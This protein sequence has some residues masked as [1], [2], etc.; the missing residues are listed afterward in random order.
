MV[1]GGCVALISPTA[2]TWLLL[3]SDTSIVLQHL[4]QKYI[5]A[6]CLLVITSSLLA[7]DE[8]FLYLNTKSLFRANK[9]WYVIT[10]TDRHSALMKSHLFLVF[11]SELQRLSIEVM[12]Q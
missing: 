3:C 8:L 9:K 4:V 6:Y 1:G 7:D 10:Y 12:R 2:V 11:I 5:L